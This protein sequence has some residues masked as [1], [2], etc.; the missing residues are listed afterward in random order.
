MRYTP[1]LVSEHV[2][3]FSTLENLAQSACFK[4]VSGEELAIA[5][6][7]IMVD[8]DLG[9]FHYCPAQE[10]LWGK[11]AHDPLLVFNSFGFTICHVHAHMFTMLARAAGFQARVANIQGHEG[12]EI[13][14][15]DAWHY[16]DADVQYFHRKREAPYAIASREE[17]FRD[18]SLVDQQPRPSHPYGFPD[19]LPEKFRKLYETPPEYPDL[20]EEQIHA[21]DFV[22]RPGEELI[23]YFYQRGRWHVFPHYPDMFRQYPTETGPEGP[24]ER[25][26]P[27]RQWGNG[28]F[29]YAP[30]L[31]PNFR[32]LELGA[33]EVD[34][35]TLT[36]RGLAS[37]KEEGTARFAFESPYIFC[38]IPDPLR[39]VPSAGGATLCAHFEIPPGGDAEI[40]ACA[41]HPN[42]APCWERLWASKGASGTQKVELD[43][44]ALVDGTYRA[45]L[46]F[47]LKGLGTTLDSFETKLWCMV[48][49]H[50]LPALKH[51]G[52]NSMA[53]R[54]G[55]RYGLNTRHFRLEK[56]LGANSA[57]DDAA[58]TENLR[59]DPA[60][61]SLA[62]PQDA[63]KPWSLTYELKAPRGQLAWLSVYAL[64]ESLRPG[65]AHDGTP[66][67]IEISD[68]PAGPWKIICE[69][70]PLTHPEGWHFGAFG[71][72]QFN[73][74]GSAGYV[75]FS[76]KKGLKGFR[77][78]AHYVPDAAPVLAPLE[79]EHTWYEDDPSVG[80]RLRSHLE[81][82]SESAHA[83]EVTCEQIPHNDAVV[84]RVPSPPRA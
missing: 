53:L 79:I 60:H 70:S 24:T 23:R 49:P 65:E 26:W 27:R 11:D 67:R 44:T 62:L 73:G 29:R 30:T 39:R 50:S 10:P 38:G 80:R 2:P 51:D 84:L 19:R 1:W 48:S 17:L 75:R 74:L 43:F 36:E 12:A 3:D 4:G 54:C 45:E 6:W 37:E 71:R 5:L 57:L 56:L 13:F 69:R 59:Y 61:R 41:T 25:F 76:S 9:I 16:F 31:R 78:S 58:H 22:L 46:R 47:R 34:G 77:V 66:A 21:A 15:D 63:Q 81:P 52:V 8:R 7:G 14:Y 20:L 33:D 68:S 40:Q 18:P 42:K 55:D 28:V 32:D 35:L 72:E 83:Y 82:I 64:F